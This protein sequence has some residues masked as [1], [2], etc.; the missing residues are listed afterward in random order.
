[1]GREIRMVPP[2]WQH[3]PSDGGRGGQYKPLYYGAGG[4]FE[5]K[6]NKWL[7]ECAK[8]QAGERP[9]YAGDDAPMYYWDWDVPPPSVEDHM[10]VG[11]P[12]SEC[13]HY[14]LYEST[15]EGTPL[16]PACATLE[17]VAEYAANHCTTFADFKTTKEQWL[18]MLSPGGMVMTRIAPGL[19]AL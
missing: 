13:T 4:R 1:M 7:A 17:E 19:I 11:V 5:A 6:A 8:W 9:D 15:T 3:P 16:S 18:E 12:D 14:M 2:N 10:L